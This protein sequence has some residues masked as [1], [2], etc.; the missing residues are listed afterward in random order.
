MVYLA[1]FVPILKLVEVVRANG[2]FE[3]VFDASFADGLLDFGVV[4]VRFALPTP[5]GL[6]VLPRCPRRHGGL[7]PEANVER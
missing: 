2:M 1:A 6:A 3:R 4:G 7:S 5:Y